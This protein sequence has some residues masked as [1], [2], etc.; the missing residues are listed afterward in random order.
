[1][2]EYVTQDEDEET[3]TTPRVRKLRRHVMRLA[4]PGSD[5]SE[6]RSQSR[7]SANQR[8]RKHVLRQESYEERSPQYYFDHSDVVGCSGVRGC[9]NVIST[10]RAASLDQ[11][12]DMNCTIKDFV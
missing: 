5:Q 8:L 6:D 2:S 3:H 12:L 4:T 1:M 7:D 10:R 9:R 11:Y